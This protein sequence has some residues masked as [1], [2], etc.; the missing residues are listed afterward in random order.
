M[1]LKSGMGEL[2]IQVSFCI[3]NWIIGISWSSVSNQVLEDHLTALA[4]HK[5]LAERWSSNNFSPASF[6]FLLL[7]PLSN[8]YFMP[9]WHVWLCH[10]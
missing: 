1:Y 9:L 7:C 5:C 2:I 10:K 6:K 3:Y 8:R 4:L